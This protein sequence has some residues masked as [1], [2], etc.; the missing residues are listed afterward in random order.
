MGD[1]QRV[2]IAQATQYFSTHPP[3]KQAGVERQPSADM[4]DGQPLRRPQPSGYV[5]SQ[6]SPE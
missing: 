1:N 2:K 4:S 5:K 3:G 6:P